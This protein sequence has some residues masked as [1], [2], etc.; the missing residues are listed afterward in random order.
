MQPQDTALIA[1]HA[2]WVLAADAEAGLEGFVNMQPMLPPA[3]VLPI[4]REHAP[5]Y[6][7]VREGGRRGI[8]GGRADLEEGGGRESEEKSRSHCVYCAASAL[9]L[10][11]AAV[12]QCAATPC[13]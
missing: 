3:V 1:T 13:V 4:L 5:D 9:L 7:A 8:G 2:A 12:K 11:P 10:A 6:C